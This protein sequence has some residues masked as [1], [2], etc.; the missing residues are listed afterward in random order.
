MGDH[1]SSSKMAESQ[2]AT[3]TIHAAPLSPGMSR[4]TAKLAK[5]L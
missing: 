4:V 2:S 1:S 5:H 3:R